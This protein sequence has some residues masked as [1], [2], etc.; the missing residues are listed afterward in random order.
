MFELFVRRRLRL[1]RLNPGVGKFS[2]KVNHCESFDKQ[3]IW[4]MRFIH[5]TRSS[6]VTECV[7]V[8]VLIL[9][10][11]GCSSSHDEAQSPAPVATSNAGLKNP[12]ATKSAGPTIPP[13]AE[14]LTDEEL[15]ALG[16]STPSKPPQRP[17]TAPGAE[18]VLDG[19]LPTNKQPAAPPK[20]SGHSALPP[21]AEPELDGGQPAAQAIQVQSEFPA[22]LTQWTASHFRLA[23][24]KNNPRLIQA[25]RELGRGNPA[26]PDPQANA[27]LLGELLK[28]SSIAAS[29]SSAPPGA[30][31]I[32]LPAVTTNPAAS[33]L[34]G[35]IIEALGANG[36]SDARTV[37]KSILLGNQVSDVPDRTLISLAL[38]VL[39]SHPDEDNQKILAAVLTVPDS[40]RPPGR[41]QVTADELQQECLRQIR[42][43]ATAEFRQRLAQRANQKVSSAASRQHL[44][45]MLTTPEAV[46]VE[47]Q[48]ELLAGGR[49]DPTTIATL[50]RL[51]APASQRV[52]EC[53]LNAT[54]GEL[55]AGAAL[56]KSNPP[57]AGNEEGVIVA[58][59][60]MTFPDTVRMAQQLWRTDVCNSVAARL[61]V[62]D[63]LPSDIALGTLAATLPCD[64]VRKS[65]ARHWE[66]RWDEE[67]TALENSPLFSSGGRDPG[68]IVVLK[69]LPRAT[70]AAKPVST[71]KGNAKANESPQSQRI[72]KE[73]AAQHAWLHI[74]ELFARSLADRFATA[75][76]N[77]P[78]DLDL[79]GTTPAKPIASVAEFDHLLDSPTQNQ[80]AAS[81]A[82]G[83]SA[84]NLW[85][86]DLGV[87]LPAGVRVKS[88]YQINWPAGL[89][90]SFGQAAIGSLTVHF[91]RLTAEGQMD[92]LAAAF[93]RPLKTAL[94]RT[95]ETGRWV[96]ALTK[97]QDGR[98]RSID[99]FINRVDT[100]PAP[101]RGTVER[102]TVDLVSVEIPD[103]KAPSVTRT[104]PAVVS[105]AAQDVGLNQ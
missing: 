58:N 54:P 62:S 94:L 1:H 84:S 91:V 38:R 60:E 7:A 50:D 101:P 105:R 13:G 20:P 68:L 23:R 51:V 53:I 67:A 30:D 103:P 37:L 42:P 6:R 28:P 40:I 34:A 79:A 66:N 74:S 33:G 75:A 63:N 56:P 31:A 44:L 69:E 3:S 10:T 61:D 76:E 72:S 99:V 5:L 45:A 65:L 49:A 89:G 19:E 35:A 29:G 4:L 24:Q 86:S 16:R 8:A 85:P 98:A 59:R 43:I 81:A 64:M 26:N 25:V 77:R 100:G 52:L 96:D 82:S 88:A 83:L 104:A 36:T 87:D 21:G 102:L 14:P 39:V 70:P 92:G 12:S 71:A 9:C 22:D 78:R 11:D 95:T 46:N 80:S 27:Q 18:P 48:V 41:G 32:D 2:H 47:A 97:L 57:A 17:A 55:A 93:A 73:Q 15:V 90:T